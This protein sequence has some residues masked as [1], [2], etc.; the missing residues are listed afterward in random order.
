MKRLIAALALTLSTIGGVAVLGI[1][2]ASA[3]GQVCHD[4]QVTV[5]GQ[6]LVS[7]AQ[8]NAL[9]AAPALP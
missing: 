3:D 8:C 6:Q 1:P 5:N 2:A 4:V 9:P 7:D